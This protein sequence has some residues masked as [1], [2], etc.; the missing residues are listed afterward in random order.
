MVRHDDLAFR[1]AED[2]M[3]IGLSGKALVPAAVIYVKV[4]LAEF[5]STLG[6]PTSATNND[7]CLLCHCSKDNFVCFDNWDAI[8]SH[9]R[10]K[11]W[12]GYLHA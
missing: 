12:E 3:Y 5:G 2:K 7:P 8:T 9:W 1:A 10:P 11:T 6:F 4:D